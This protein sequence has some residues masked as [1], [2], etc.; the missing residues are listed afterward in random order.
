MITFRRENHAAVSRASG[1]SK[2]IYAV[3]DVHGRYDLL[4]ALLSEIRRDSAESYPD[5]APTI[6][7]CGDYI[8]R[9]P[10][11][12]AVLAALVW[13]Q[14]STAVDARMLQGNHEAMLIGFLQDPEAYGLWLS[15]DGRTTVQSYGLKIPDDADFGNASFLTNVRDDLLDVMPIS[16]YRL[17]K[18]L[19]LYVE[20]GD[21]VFVHAGVAPGIPIASQT[22][23]DVLWIEDEFLHHPR[24][25]KSI[26]VHGHT[27]KHD[28]AEVLPHRIGIDTGAY[29]SGVL[30]A[31]RISGD[32]LEVIQAVGAACAAQ[33]MR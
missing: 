23:D 10:A 24:P 28:R 7:L 8:D 29:Q 19:Q 31:L 18:N 12:A 20:L 9:G 30:T 27:W 2:P 4:R 22:A 15:I 16:H 1:G 26:V 21:Y 3:G 32:T 14:R 25:S 6:V 5:I 17:V 33:G 11:S 13:L